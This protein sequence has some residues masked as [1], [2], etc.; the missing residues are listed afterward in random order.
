M[1]R[2]LGQRDRLNERVE[3][4]AKLGTQIMQ[5]KPDSLEHVLLSKALEV[6]WSA[7]HVM[8]EELNKLHAAGLDQ[9]IYPVMK[10]T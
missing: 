9:T 4:R 5:T 8:N 7:N 6:F 1:G 3:M 10:D 2:Y